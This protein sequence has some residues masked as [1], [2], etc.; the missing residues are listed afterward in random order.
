M[1]RLPN[2]AGSLVGAGVDDVDKHG[3]IYSD[4]QNMRQI[5]AL[6]QADFGDYSNSVDGGV[7]RLA[8]GFTMAIN[9]ITVSGG[10]GLRQ[11]LNSLFGSFGRGDMELA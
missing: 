6:G 2:E 5:K 4:Y 7:R 10:P 1:L 8:V 3:I 11:F 9:N